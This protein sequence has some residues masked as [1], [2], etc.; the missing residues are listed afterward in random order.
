MVRM[1]GYLLKAFP[2]LVGNEGSPPHHVDIAAKNVEKLREFVNS[3][4]SQHASDASKS[5]VRFLRR[6]M[7]ATFVRPVHHRAEFVQRKKFAVLS[8]PFLSENNWAR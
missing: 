5:V 6:S 7:V 3:D 1:R 8:H 4:S 2:V